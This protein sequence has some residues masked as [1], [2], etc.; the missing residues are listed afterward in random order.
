MK[1]AL[2]SLVAIPFIAFG[3]GSSGK[4][5]NDDGMLINC[6]TY[7]IKL[8]EDA[9]PMEEAFAVQMLGE[10]VKTNF[11]DPSPMFEFADA[12]GFPKEQAR[13]EF[14]SDAKALCEISN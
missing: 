11:V 5:V 2:F 10:S 8:A 3:C 13:A 14:E 1:K 9:A 12:M 7:R 6:S 4:V